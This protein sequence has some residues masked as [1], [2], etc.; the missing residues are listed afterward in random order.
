MKR[1]L[2]IILFVAALVSGAQTKTQISAGRSAIDMCVE[3]CQNRNREE[4]K[5]CNTLYPPNSQSAE[6]R[7][8]L[9]KAKNKFDLYRSV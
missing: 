1:C 9:D 8:C 5:L 6:H 4:L 3:E 7:E 2:T